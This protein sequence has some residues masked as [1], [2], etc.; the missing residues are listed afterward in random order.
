MEIGKSFWRPLIWLTE[1]LRPFMSLT[2]KRD[3]AG[4]RMPESIRIDFKRRSAKMS[5]WV[6]DFPDHGHH[7]AFIPSLRLS[8]YGANKE[9]A[10]DMLFK[11]AMD[12]MFDNLMNM[13][14][15]QLMKELEKFGWKRHRLFHKEFTNTPYID[16]HGI[17]KDF[18]LPS[19]TKVGQNFV[20]R[21]TAVAA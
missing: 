16:E 17:L 14:D 8:G 10:I 21:Q 1:L 15:A 18:N 12:D 11:D 2:T 19:D 4:A 9:E 7:I 5:L 3:T 6:V 20:S 13:P